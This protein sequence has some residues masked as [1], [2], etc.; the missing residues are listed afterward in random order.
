MKKMRVRPLLVLLTALGVFVAIITVQAAP[1]VTYVNQ[2]YSNTAAA[3]SFT[4]PNNYGKA[5]TRVSNQL[6]VL[7]NGVDIQ[8]VQFADT[9]YARCA[10][11]PGSN[12][13]TVNVLNGATLSSGSVKVSPIGHYS[14]LSVTNSSVTFTIDQPRK[15][16]IDFNHTSLDQ[17]MVFADPIEDYTPDLSDPSVINATSYVSDITGA[18]DVSSQFQ[19]AINAVAALNGGQGGILYVPNGIY[20]L[21]TTIFIKSN[22]TIYL[23]NGALLQAKFDGSYSVNGHNIFLG[24]GN[25]TSS[26]SANAKLIGRGT[27]DC[28]GYYSR[29]VS[30]GATKIH[31]IECLNGSSNITVKD[32]YIRNGASWTV[33]VVGTNG[34]YGINYKMINDLRKVSGSSLVY[35]RNRTSYTGI[36]TGDAD[37]AISNTDG[38]DPD[39][40]SNVYIDGIFEHTFD[41]AHAIKI[42]GDNINSSNLYIRNGVYWCMKSALKIGTEVYGSSS[43]PTVSNV[44]YEDNYVIHS[45]RCLAVYVRGTT[46]SDAGVANNV[47]YRNNKSEYIA[48]YTGDKKVHLILTN[49]Y[50]ARPP[51]DIRTVKVIDY[52]ALDPS[53]TT[54]SSIAGMSG[55]SLTGPFQF[56]NWPGN[57]SQ[58]SVQYAPNPTYYGLYSNQPPVL[59]PIG[60]RT[61]VRNQNLSISL[62]AADP[63]GG[64]LTFSAESLPTGATLNGTVFNWIPSTSGLYGVLFKVSDGEFIDYEYVTINV[65]STGGGATPTPTVMPTP[66]PTATPTPGVT[67]TPTPGGALI[68]FR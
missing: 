29:R 10:V 68:S 54:A 61:G 12:T 46:S 52:V 18:T 7:V 4:D 66:M 56:Y 63:N 67:P 17:L 45:D 21:G 3:P 42:T 51:G 57:I 38:S 34:F 30:G 16:F 39:A 36:G 65:T 20:L 58:P 13:V 6:K 44:F 50:D 11:S 37:I 27:I 26:G 19:N 47:Y 59:D 23:A 64:T 15:I 53:Y 25:S 55:N 28:N 24:F 35:K 14:N 41:D 48:K 8:T 1:P 9:N 2:F 49:N 33:H 31:T 43:G 60:T 5:V 40:S 62:S 32:V 22:V